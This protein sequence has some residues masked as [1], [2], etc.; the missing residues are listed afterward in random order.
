MEAGNEVAGGVP[1]SSKD[2][3]GSGPLPRVGQL[4]VEKQKGRLNSVFSGLIFHKAVEK[5][6]KSCPKCQF[7]GLKPHL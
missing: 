5:Y 4:G 2:D 1:V 3:V 7:N 6:C